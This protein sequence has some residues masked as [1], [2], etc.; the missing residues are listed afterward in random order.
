MLPLLPVRL[1]PL[2]LSVASAVEGVSVRCSCNVQRVLLQT[3]S[4]HCPLLLHTQ[5]A[6]G[7]QVVSAP[8]RGATSVVSAELLLA[9]FL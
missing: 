2:L 7:R 3:A 8:C 5:A 9:F 6:G 4:S 1:P